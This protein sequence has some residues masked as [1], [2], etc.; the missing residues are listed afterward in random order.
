MWKCP[1][2]RGQFRRKRSKG[3]IAT[4]VDWSWPWKNFFRRKRSL[5]FVFLWK[6][7]MLRTISSFSASKWKVL[8]WQ[9]SSFYVAA[10][11]PIHGQRSIGG[12]WQYSIVAT[13]Q[14]SSQEI[15]CGL[16]N[17]ASFVVCPLSVELEK[18]W[19]WQAWLLSWSA[20]YAAQLVMCFTWRP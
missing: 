16:K 7:K 9:R 17:L 6:V 2:W 4:V 20:Q 10:C 19:R 8:S 18:Q 14:P 13:A 1:F 12:L 15:S 11:G 3:Q 5:F